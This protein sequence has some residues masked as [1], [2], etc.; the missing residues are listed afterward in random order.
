M[1]PPPPEPSEEANIA[2][3]VDFLRSMEES[4][5]KKTSKQSKR[6]S[7]TSLSS[8][9]KNI[10]AGK[11]SDAF[12]RFEHSNSSSN[13]A[14]PPA[15]T[16]SPL[17]SL[18]RHHDLTPI[19]GSEATDGRSDDGQVLE[20][21][22][23]MTP[24]MRREVERRRLSEEEKRVAAAGAEYRKRLADREPGVAQAGLP[25]SIGGVSRA[26]SIQNKVQNLLD[27]SQ[28]STHITRT[29]QGYGHFTESPAQEL[30]RPEIP[31]KPVGGVMRSNVGLGVGIET[32]RP[33][34]PV[35]M[36]PD[37]RPVSMMPNTSGRPTAPPKPTHLYKNLTS[38]GGRPMSPP[39]PS[40]LNKPL[41]HRPPMGQQ[42]QLMAPSL[43][44]QPILDM[45][46]QEKDDYL[47]DF[48]KR[49]PS[50]GAIEMVE[51]DLGA[52]AAGGRDRER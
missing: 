33:A 20:E 18:G 26:V 48:Q 25:K 46:A 39:K 36:K 5:S 15:R 42:E 44:G 16:P 35:G 37:V 45:T 41:P 7:L 50:L 29:A 51:R 3:N 8:G 21:T 34:P 31:R 12:K 24:E 38:G 17:K 2:S 23:D 10:F 19:A 1:S 27:E 28:K 32:K 47:N 6:S 9:T 30:E 22:D 11:F 49:F 52:E 13:S 40:S 4:D 14:P 43:P